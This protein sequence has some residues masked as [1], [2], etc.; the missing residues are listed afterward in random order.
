[1]KPWVR[2]S[3]QSPLHAHVEASDDER[4]DDR[5]HDEAHVSGRPPLSNS[6]HSRMHGTR[7]TGTEV[8]IFDMKAKPPVVFRRP[9]VRRRLFPYSHTWGTRPRHGRRAGSPTDPSS[10]Q[11]SVDKKGLAP[12]T[13]SN[14]DGRSAP[15]DRCADSHG[16]PYETPAA[17]GR[18][19]RRSGASDM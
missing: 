18:S 2:N 1:M 17:P 6:G 15:H 5:S 16:A 4:Y 19:D 14:R 11:D 7:K 3:G 9:P 12:S 8:T 10:H 13:T